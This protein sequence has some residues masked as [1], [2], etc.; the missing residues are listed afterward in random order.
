MDSTTEDDDQL[1][2]KIRADVDRY[3]W[4]RMGVFGPEGRPSWVYSIGFHRTYR[5]PEIVVFGFDQTLLMGIMGTIGSLVSSGTTFEAGT[6]SA[7]ILERYNCAF[8]SVD[9]QWYPLFFGRAIDYYAG[10]N[11]PILQCLYPDQHGLYPWQHG[12]DEKL[13]DWQPRLAP[14]P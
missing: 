14:N 7:E 6:E 9:E 13:R 5:H 12:F 1:G 3:G 10:S 4:N 11:F 2:K 8:R